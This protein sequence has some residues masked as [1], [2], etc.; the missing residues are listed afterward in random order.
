MKYL[1][2][3]K[4]VNT[5]SVDLVGGAEWAWISGQPVSPVIV[6][7]WRDAGLIED[8]GVASAIPTEKAKRL[9]E[10]GK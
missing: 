10:K 3:L 8:Y 9:L 6:R 7:A 2:L 1:S 5:I 4:S